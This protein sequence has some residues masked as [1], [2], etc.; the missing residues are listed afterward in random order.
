[1]IVIKGIVSVKSV[2]KTPVKQ[3]ATRPSNNY[4]QEFDTILKSFV[5][6]S[7]K[8][9][10]FEVVFSYTWR[11]QILMN[12]SKSHLDSLHYRNYYP[13]TYMHLI[14]NSDC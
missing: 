6:I 3:G 2:S 9:I 13:C 5:V 12:S 14:A 11:G 10:A 1:M 4:N 8:R 7:N